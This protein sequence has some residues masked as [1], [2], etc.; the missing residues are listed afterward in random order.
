M[1]DRSRIVKLI[2][3]IS[4]DDRKALVHWGL[5]WY[6]QKAKVGAMPK[7]VEYRFKIDAY[8]PDTIP[9]SRLADYLGHL[10][11]MLGQKDNVHLLRLEGGSTVPV[12]AVEWEAAP[13]VDRRVMDVKNNDGP[14][15]AI[16]ARQ[17]LEKLLIEDNASAEL[18]NPSGGRILYFHGRRLA[19]QP[20][21]G[22]FK[23]ET[24]LD[25]FVILIGGENDPVPVHLRNGELDYNCRA[26]RAIAKT[27]APYM[28][29]TKLRAFGAATWFRNELGRWELRRFLIEKI[30][31]LKS[32]PLSRAVDRL[33]DIQAEWKTHDDPLTELDEIR[34]GPSG[35]DNPH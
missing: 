28:F 30:T 24:T 25:G 8:S 11:D 7:I 32:E 5:T 15:E 14:A 21:Y 33:R 19:G 16:K 34:R 17:T 12:V 9:M 3:W 20:E 1:R 29:D 27:L 6:D 22:P 23:Q 13:K 2:F 4:A 10:A 35:S 31:P 18:L 26:S